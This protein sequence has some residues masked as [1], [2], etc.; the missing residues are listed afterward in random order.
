LIYLIANDFLKL[1]TDVTLQQVIASNTYLQSWAETTAIKQ[2]SNYLRQKYD[3]D[4][5]FSATLLY[6]PTKSYKAGNRVYLNA[7]AYNASSTYPLKALVLQAGKVYQC[8]T[9]IT[10]PEA[11]TIGKWTLLGD[12]YDMFYASFPKPLFD[13]N[14]YYN[15]DD[16]IFWKDK[17][18]TA[19]I[20]THVYTHGEALQ[21]AEY[22]NIPYKNYF[23]DDPVNGSQQWGSGTAYTVAADTLTDTTKWTNGDNRHSLLVMYVIDIAIYNLYGRIA[24]KSIPEQRTDRYNAVMNE[25]RMTARGE[26]SSDIQ[27][28]QPDKGG[29]IRWGSNVKAQNSY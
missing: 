23:P 24:P 20:P 26:I 8:S 19:L 15:K 7:S 25:L 27:K 29:R 2:V 13:T 11:F 1:I 6:D 16:Q 9:A 28:I 18:Y 14:A 17:T 10:V 12:Q 3:V 4:N 22:G 21:Y 5:E